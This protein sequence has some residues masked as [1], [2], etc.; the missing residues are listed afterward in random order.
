MGIVARCAQFK[1]VNHPASPSSQDRND[2]A[3]I[4]ADAHAPQAAAL[5]VEAIAAPQKLRRSTNDGLRPA[6]DDV[7]TSLDDKAIYSRG[8]S[9][10]RW[11]I[12]SERRQD[13]LTFGGYAS[14]VGEGE[15]R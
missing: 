4:G 12:A 8:P 11:G 7:T 10:Q 13:D 6:L 9:K 5:S 2:A 15:A 3:R 1:L 14:C